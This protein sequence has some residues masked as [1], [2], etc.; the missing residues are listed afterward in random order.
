MLQKMKIATVV[1][2]FVLFG[3]VSTTAAFAQSGS[4]APS[5]M[6]TAAPPLPTDSRDSPGNPA[7]PNCYPDINHCA[8]YPTGQLVKSTSSQSS[9]PQQPQQPQQQK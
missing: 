5:S 1:T 3:L 2:A 7:G 9:Q 4:P 8:D 6:Q